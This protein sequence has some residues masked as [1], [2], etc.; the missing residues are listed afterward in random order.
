MCNLNIVAL[1]EMRWPGN[2][3]IKHNETTI[4]FSRCKGNKHAFG[5]G[6][7]INNRLLAYVKIF[8][9]INK[10]ICFICLRT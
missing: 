7:M 5:V 1:Q 6:F 9:T 3:S 10:R 4:F 8:E 2:C